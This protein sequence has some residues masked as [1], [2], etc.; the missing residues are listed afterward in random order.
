MRSP[1]C[2]EF[3]YGEEREAGEF[4]EAEFREVSF[5]DARPLLY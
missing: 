5:G 3:N 1:G 4:P 2:F